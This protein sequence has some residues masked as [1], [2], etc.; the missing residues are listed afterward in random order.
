MD[1]IVSSSD[2]KSVSHWNWGQG[3]HDSIC[4]IILCFEFVYML[5]IV[6]L[7]INTTLCEKVCQ[8]LATGRWFSPVSSTNKTDITIAAVFSSKKNILCQITIDIPIENPIIATGIS[9][10]FGAIRRKEKTAPFLYKLFHN[11][12]FINPYKPL[13]PVGGNPVL[14]A[15]GMCNFSKRTN[16]IISTRYIRKP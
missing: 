7:C 3:A 13:P 11:N 1:K 8:W 16:G 5:Y 12:N 4:Y 6:C 15:V 10:M 2:N 9:T 14:H